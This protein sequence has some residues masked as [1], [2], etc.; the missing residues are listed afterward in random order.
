LWVSLCLQSCSKRNG[1]VSEFSFV[2]RSVSDENQR[3]D[4]FLS[5]QIPGVSRS[6]IKRI[7]EE[8]RVL[9]NGRPSKGSCRLKGGD[10]I[11]GVYSRDEP[12]RLEPQKIP[13]DTIFEDDSIVV[14]NKPAGMVV[15]PGAGAKNN[16]LAHALKFH[17]PEIAWIGPE[18]RPGIVHRL[19]KD[20]SGL[21]V[22]ALTESAFVDL[23]LQFKSRKVDK[24][25]LALVW[26][27]MPGPEGLMDWP[28]GRHPKQGDRMSIKTKHPRDAKT[29]YEVEIE[30]SD[31]SLLRV[32]PITGRTHQI[33]VH[34]AASGHPVVGD[35]V[36]GRARTKT[37]CPRQFLHA[38]RLEF[39]HPKTGLRIHF[40]TPL[41]EDLQM[42]L[43]TL[44]G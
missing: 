4:V 21:L 42:F 43:D 13:L 2:I 3:L 28:L 19:D 31:F 25:Y 26:G 41:P 24:T 18:V 20:T 29:L 11:Q 17:F 16:T 34:L 27:H 44:E 9:V 36:Y 6:Q 35:R 5:G 15:H 37:A 10:L 39:N 7:I 32:K 30:Y 23:K 38:F 14:I 40:T 33:R 8:G 12:F 22:A 1:R